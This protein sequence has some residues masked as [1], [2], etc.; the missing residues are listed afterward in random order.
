MNTVID[1]IK[2]R[3]G[4]VI[5]I[6]EAEALAFRASY[7][8]MLAQNDRR[9]LYHVRE[10]IL[11]KMANYTGKPNSG[12][13]NEIKIQSELK[14]GVIVIDGNITR[15]VNFGEIIHLT[16]SP[17]MLNCVN[18]SLDRHDMLVKGGKVPTLK[19]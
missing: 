11:Q 3:E 7:K 17:R 12:I 2:A 5:S 15:D 4:R 19:K 13:A 18:F 16:P 10:P 8:Y 1:I 6:E 9:L 14:N